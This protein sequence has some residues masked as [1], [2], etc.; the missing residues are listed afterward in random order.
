[1]SLDAAERSLL[2][3]LK[4]VA[5]RWRVIHL[6]GI[7]LLRARYARSK[8]G[9]LWLTISNALFI[10][11]AGAVWSIIWQTDIDSYLPYVA[12]GLVI[13][14]FL[15]STIAECTGILAGDA[16]LYVNDRVPFLVSTAAH[17]Y[18]QLIILLHNIPIIVVVVLWSESA[19]FDFYWWYPLAVVVTF[20][21][22]AAACYPLAFVCARFRDVGQLV[23]TAT[24]IS[25]LVTPVMWKIDFLPPAVVGYFYLNPFAAFLDLL[26]N[27]LVGEPVSAFAWPSVLVWTALSV[28]LAFIAHRQFGRRIIFWL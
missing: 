13:Y 7:Q 23:G 22:L 25:F 1:M 18:R 28:G 20:V 21:F 17:V 5:G 14:Q 2:A 4:D 6:L 19:R 24:Q 15:S 3:E 9:Q 26:R 8:F 11:S 10:L 16:R 27:P 12:G